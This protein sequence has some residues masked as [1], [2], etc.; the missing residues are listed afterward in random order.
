MVPTVDS[1]VE[2]A[3]CG[4]EED[5]VIGPLLKPDAREVPS[6]LSGGATP[7]QHW[8]GSQEPGSE[9]REEP[10]SRSQK[11][12]LCP[13]PTPSPRLRDF[14]RIKDACLRSCLVC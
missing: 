4:W 14:V 13:N 8:S 10:A 6:E 1:E 12:N 5:A 7:D 9:G 3:P 2:E 11:Y